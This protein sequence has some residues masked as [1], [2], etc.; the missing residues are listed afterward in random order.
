MGSR[1]SRV[2]YDSAESYP[3]R[4]WLVSNRY[5]SWSRNCGEDQMRGSK[6]TKMKNT[7]LE[8]CIL[9]LSARSKKHACLF[10][11][12]KFLPEMELSNIKSRVAGLLLS[13]MFSNAAT[14]AHHSGPA[15]PCRTR[16]RCQRPG[17]K[18]DTAPDLVPARAPIACT[19]CDSPSRAR[20]SAID[21]ALSMKWVSL[22]TEGYGYL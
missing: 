13:S 11:S 3:P 10:G 18:R 6:P 14:V 16:S 22:M 8:S 12:P 4:P 7:E 20:S 17:V 15:W 21:A 5:P 19:T 2:Q 1:T 9:E